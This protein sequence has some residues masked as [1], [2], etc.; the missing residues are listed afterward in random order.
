MIYIMSYSLTTFDQFLNPKKTKKINK[1]TNFK[2]NNFY[3]NIL[4]KKKIF[5]LKKKIFKKWKLYI[6]NKLNNFNKNKQKLNNNYKKKLILIY[7]PLLHVFDNNEKDN[8]LYQDNH[9]IFFVEKSIDWCHF[10]NKNSKKY[11]K[12]KKIGIKYYKKYQYIYDKLFQNNRDIYDYSTYNRNIF[13]IEKYFFLQL[14]YNSI[15][16]ICKNLSYSYLINNDIIPVKKQ[17]EKH[18]NIHDSI[19]LN[20]NFKDL[21]VR[22]TFVDY[23]IRKFL[24][25]KSFGPLK[26]LNTTKEYFDYCTINNIKSDKELIKKVFSNDFYYLLKNKFFNLFKDLKTDII[27]FNNNLNIFGEPDLIS[28]QSIIDSKKK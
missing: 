12:Y 19:S 15:S 25:K 5:T 7:D 18:I 26:Y 28:N 6:K 14:N 16:K 1:Y 4:Q 2:K 23:C 17:I 8:L 21:K 11:K 10:Y 24:N 27:I 13:C 20:I 9:L 3:L 22:G